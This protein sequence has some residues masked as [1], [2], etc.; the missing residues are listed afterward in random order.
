MKKLIAYLI[1]FLLMA[2]PT[3]SFAATYYGCASANINA[4]NTFCATPTGSCTGNDPVSGATAMAGTHTL[5]ANGCTIVVNASF[6]TAKI[7]TTDGD[8]VGP[9][10]AG[11]G[12]TLAAGSGYVATVAEIEAGTTHCLVVGGAATS[13]VASIVSTTIKGSS[14]TNAKY[15]IQD[16]HTNTGVISITGNSTGGGGETTTS[17][18][19]VGVTTIGRT[20]VIGSCTADKSPGCSSVLLRGNRLDSFDNNG[21]IGGSQYDFANAPATAYWR[22]VAT[23]GASYGYLIKDP[24]EANVKSGTS[25]GQD[26]DGALTG[27]LSTGGGGAWAY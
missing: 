17:Y 6:T 4:D 23:G 19:V 5:Y 21:V 24:G 8:G 1:L 25:Y 18:G 14:T 15:G 20:L 7:A 3:W 13:T 26:A 22:Y 12:F 27:T 10:E 16:T 9:A 11:G 2:M